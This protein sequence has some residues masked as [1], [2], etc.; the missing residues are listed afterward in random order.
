MS[1]QQRTFAPAFK[2]E[3]ASLVLDQG[4]SCPEA[5]AYLPCAKLNLR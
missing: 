3:A 1:R 4:Y 5:A 2:R